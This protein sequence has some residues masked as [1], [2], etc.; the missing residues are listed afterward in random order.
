MNQTLLT[1]LFK[2]IEGN[3]EEPLVRIAYSIIEDE[4][5]KGHTKL[6]ERLDTILEG[7]LAKVIEPQRPQ[8][9]K[10]TKSKDDIFSIPADRRYKLPL[11]THIENDFLRHDMVLAPSVEEKVLRI[12]KEYIEL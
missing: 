11:A 6:A 1:R 5:K 3:K 7:N 9:L 12:E 10:L 4:R 8:V 2:S